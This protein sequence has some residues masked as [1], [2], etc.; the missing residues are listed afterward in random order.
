M[1]SHDNAINFLQQLFCYTIEEASPMNKMSKW[2]PQ[3]NPCGQVIV[4]GAGKAAA[5]MA[6]EWERIWPQ[7]YPPLSGVVVT[8]YGHSIPTKHIKVLEA[9]HPLPDSAGQTA[10]QALLNAVSGLN[11]Q[12]QVYYLV[13][14]G[15][16]ALTTLP[17]SSITLADKQYN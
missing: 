1:L 3:K 13:S 4:V 5:A 11:P 9:S 16:S 7:D 6:A 12:D 15:A 17:V 10:A 14:G 2:I 8:R